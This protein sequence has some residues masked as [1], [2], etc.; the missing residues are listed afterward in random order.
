MTGEYISNYF[1]RSIGDLNIKG[2][3]YAFQKVNPS[4]CDSIF[5]VASD[6]SVDTDQLLVNVD[7]D[8]KAVRNLDYNGLPY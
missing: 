7:F 3:G 8:I 4:L 6:S 1:K 2:I 5:G